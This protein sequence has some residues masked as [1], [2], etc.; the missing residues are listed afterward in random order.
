[1]NPT[2]TQFRK[3]F[4]LLLVG[5][6]TV[7]LFWMLRGFLLTILV[8]AVFAGLLYPVFEEMVDRFRGRRNAAAAFTVVL[9]LII[10][11]VPTLMVGGLVFRQALEITENIRP[12]V[13]R[14]VAEPSYLDH[15]LER[16]PGYD[17]VA[18]Y[19]GHIVTKV[20]EIVNS[21]GSFLV[22]SLSDGTRVTV[23][24]VFNFFIALYT[25]FF[26]FLDGPKM[27][28]AI[29][30][31]LPLFHDEKET[32]KERFVSITRA[33][34][35][36]TLVIGVIQGVMGGM[37]FWVVG[38]PNAAF[39]TVVMSALSILPLIGAALVWVP[40]A[41]ILFASGAVGKA[42]GLTLF[43]GLVVGSVDNI[44]RPSL[45][46]RDS[47]LHDLVILFST[48]GG[49]AVF[50]PLGFILG[51]ILAGLFVSSWQIFGTAYRTELVDSSSRIVSTESIASDDKLSS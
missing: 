30:D 41:I 6:V 25:M 40:A 13:E 4:L 31:H 11:V 10:V 15:R 8:A 21:I 22:A 5:M 12:T 36:G 38:I 17:I 14:I 34:V 9:T 39:W 27:L 2:D 44:L 19:R 29:L 37:A 3:A 51:P 35:K 1:M 7:A 28:G 33:T 49:L 48:L 45:V 32:L 43:C 26:L 16:L 42:I 24:F 20:G 47:R 18:P 23:S 46:G 50:G